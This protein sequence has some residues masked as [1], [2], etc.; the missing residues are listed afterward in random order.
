M[1]RILPDITWGICLLFGSIVIYTL[2]NRLIF[3]TK[4][5]EN[6]ESPSSFFTFDDIISLTGRR[7]IN[8]LFTWP[9]VF[10]F[11]ALSTSSE[12]LVKAARDFISN[13]VVTIVPGQTGASLKAIIENISGPFAPL[14]VLIVTLLL[15]APYA[16]VVLEKFAELVIRVSGYRVA[17]DAAALNFANQML[18]THRF[19][20][21]QRA[22]G[23]KLNISLPVKEELVSCSD[24]N[25]LAYQILYLK[26]RQASDA[27]MGEFLASFNNTVIDRGKI[28]PCVLSQPIK[29]SE[30]KTADQT[31]HKNGSAKPTASIGTSSEPLAVRLIIIAF[32]LYGILCLLYVAVVPQFSVWITPIW[33]V[34]KLG[35][36]EWPLPQYWQTLAYSIGQRT[37]SFVFTLAAGYYLFSARR[38]L[39]GYEPLIRTFL[40]TAGIQFLLSFLSNVVFLIITLAR[41]DQFIFGYGN[42]LRVIASVTM[43]SE[44]VAYSIVPSIAL[45]MSIY[46]SKS[47]YSK[48]KTVILLC[49][50]CAF[51][52]SLSQFLN[53]TVGQRYIGYYWHQLLLGLYLTFA[54]F[55]AARVVNDATFIKAELNPPQSELAAI[56]EA[57][58]MTGVSEPSN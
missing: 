55:L 36:V 11:L 38:S 41:Q 57:H 4:T 33:P 18:K 50:V 5:S 23:D 29:S 47:E 31:N 52:F 27:G 35:P 16:R 22:I 32:M 21:I 20:D 17:V 2:T 25:I 9:L 3:D 26:H 1:Q 34:Q 53:E 56:V 10:L 30:A 58:L 40:Y 46:C 14:F 7:N 6:I 19:H 15:Y 51:S 37:V 44:L 8:L 39:K 48:T 43:I 28:V 49:F 12:A 42:G 45:G 24:Q 54:Y 13:Y